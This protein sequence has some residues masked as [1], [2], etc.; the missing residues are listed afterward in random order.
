MTDT[1]P[2]CDSD[3]LD[4]EIEFATGICQD[5][6]LVLDE[7]NQIRDGATKDSNISRGRGDTESDTEWF[8]ELDVRDSSEQQ[9]INLLE[10]VDDLSEQLLL[11]PEERV[12]SAQLLTEAWKQNFLH[13]RNKQATVGAA[14]YASC[15]E[16]GVPRPLGVVAEDVAVAKPKLRDTY[17]QLIDHLGMSVDPSRPAEYVSFLGI[18][19][20]VSDSEV[21]SAETILQE[22]SE[23]TVGNP[24]GIAAAALY[25][26]SNESGGNITLEDAAGA[27]GLVKETV[28]KKTRDF[29]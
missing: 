19:L 8:E 18:Q 6:G 20:G 3:A 5:C 21:D 10:M 16:A 26:A 7:V 29:E 2:A 12:R 14:I 13:G 4:S 9:L 23:K 25:L 24:A 22:G 27:A 11:Q 15:R 1:C 17:K 28:W